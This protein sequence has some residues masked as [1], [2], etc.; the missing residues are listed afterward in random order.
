MNTEVLEGLAEGDEVVAAQMTAEELAAGAQ[1]R[2]RGGMR[3]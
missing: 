2:M 3:L 1:V